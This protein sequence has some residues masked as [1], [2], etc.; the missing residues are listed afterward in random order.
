MICEN[1]NEEETPDN[2]VISGHNPYTYDL[3]GDEE[4]YDLCERCRQNLAEDV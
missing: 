2:E 4:E 1:C 3:Y